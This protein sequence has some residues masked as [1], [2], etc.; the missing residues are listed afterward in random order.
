MRTKDNTK[1]E[2]VECLAC[3]VVFSG[4]ICDYRKYC[5]HECR[6]KKPPFNKGKKGI[7]VAWNKGIEHSAVK[8]EK[9]G[10]WKGGV[11]T[12]DKR[13][14]SLK[15]KELYAGREK[16][17]QCEVCYKTCQTVFD[18]CH[19]NLSFRGWI[20]RECNLALGHVNDKPWIL[21][22]LAQYLEN[23]YE[24]TKPK[25]ITGMLYKDH[26]TLH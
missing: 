1:W 19:K 11:T 14:Y 15:L 18:H 13:L 17:N 20:C 24:E 16:S 21:R 6:K 26:G 22:R 7:Q 4:R 2:D 8:G 25:V 12:I 5:S 23:S 3:S 9:N 10:N